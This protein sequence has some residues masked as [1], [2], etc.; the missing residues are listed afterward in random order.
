MKIVLFCHSLVSDWNHG[1]AHFLRGVATELLARGHRVEVYEP[2]GGWSVTNLLEE[3]GEEP[4]REF[5]ATYP[6]LRTR[7]YHWAR[8]D[9]GQALEG[10]DLVLVHEWNEPNLIR[11]LG[12]HRKQGAGY[13][14][15]FHDTHHRCVTDPDAIAALDLSGYDGLLA[16]G[17]IV[18]EI[19]LQRG[20][21][22]RAWVWHEAA[23]LRVFRPRL[24]PQDR[25]DLVWVG[26]W[27]DE[28]R[29]AEL[30]EY[31][32][33]PVEALRLRARV[34]GVRYPG[35]ARRALAGAGIEYAG[36][37]ANFKVPEAF[38]R[39][40][41]TL[42]V[43]RRPYVAALP[44]V[45][46]IRPF[47]ALA[48]GIPLV[49]SPWEDTEGLFTPGE[50]FLVARSGREMR[51]HL[52]LVLADPELGRRLAERGRQTI[53]RRHS[54]AHRTEELLAIGRELGVGC[55]KKPAE[56][57]ESFSEKSPAATMGSSTE[58]R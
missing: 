3:H 29:A 20:W 58:D 10:A 46:T 17:Q 12:K 23:D 31:L 44:G 26:N 13:K 18:R 4:L 37:L 43:P 11:R 32:V 56:A 40:R 51:E 53:E 14:L 57:P 45:P 34:H 55:A 54:C 42:H 22:G 24:P 15:L 19:Y 28:E 7:T 9:L 41:V 36:W 5:R 39:H 6:A 48:C 33:G 49:C 38:A 25:G 8:L 35:R 16:F 21:A 2:E 27:G 52:R 30:Q 50:D 47:E 1:N